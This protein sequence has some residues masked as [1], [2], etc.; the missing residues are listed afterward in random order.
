MGDRSE[1]LFKHLVSAAVFAAVLITSVFCS[2]RAYGAEDD[3]TVS[4]QLIG[5][6]VYQWDFPY[7]DDLFRSPSEYFSTEL[8][9]ASTGLMVSAFNCEPEVLADQYQ[10]YLKGAG[11]RDIYEFG[12]DQETSKDSLAGIIGWKQID[13]FILIA[14]APR[15][16]GYGKEWAGNLE[17]GDEERHVGFN[18]AAQI[19][20]GEITRYIDGHHLD[21]AMKLWLTGF[22]RAS[23][24]S[25]LAAADMIDSGA[26][27][28]VYAYLF[29]VPRTTKDP[30]RLEYTGIFNICGKN[31]PV[32]NVPLES[33]GYERYGWDRFT[34]SVETDIHYLELLN[35]ASMVNSELTGYP[36]YYNPEINYQIHLIL[37]FLAKMFPT[38]KEYAEEFQDVIMTV[39]TE[40]E[41]E[42]MIPILQEALSQLN[43]LD[44]EEERSCE[45][46]LEY[47][48]F[49]ASEHLAADQKQVKNGYWDPDQSI[50][51]NV[52]R[53]HCPYVYIS[54]VFSGCEESRLFQTPPLFRRVSLIGNVDVAV[55]QDGRF[56]VGIDSQGNITNKEDPDDLSTAFIMR[57][58]DMTTVSLPFLEDF[59]LE[60]R[61]NKAGNLIYYNNLCD[62]YSTYGF[63][64][65]VLT[66]TLEAGE[67]DLNIT[68]ADFDGELS[69]VNGRIFNRSQ[70]D[71]N[72]SPTLVM[73]NEIGN[74]KY[75]TLEGLFQMIFYSLMAILAILFVCMV[76][77]II[78]A[79]RKKK[80]NAPYAPWF[81]IIPHLMIAI[82]LVLLTQ[83]FTVNMYSIGHMRAVC[84]GLT[85]LVMFLLS[86]RG[87]I[88]NRTLPGL[89]IAVG[90]LILGFVNAVIYQRST[91]VSASVLHFV[92]YC[93]CMAGLACI[94]VS[95]FF[96]KK[97][98]PKAA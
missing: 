59:D 97:R 25:N 69:A 52:I 26:F 19:F 8:A 83:F 67:Y 37:E 16:N 12:Y 50:A 45:V 77:A 60:I 95:T 55:R 1:R 3:I 87:L 46:L 74:S 17:V 70:I 35:E 91:L 4:F 96:I 20:E 94:A 49:I 34:P 23:A 92:I 98:Q 66:Q 42:R 82:V 71:F 2:V 36:L 30:N 68:F 47:F 9:R 14:A 75:M 57:N 29:G 93:L 90:F 38:N 88:R 64:N 54:W 89:L 80:R 43:D 24:V 22:S 33:W 53:E 61:A 76:I 5:K 31:D 41:P 18:R 7:S 13:D 21:G 51:E 73:A 28:D 10:V 39:W 65:K 79:I 62:S 78:H 27:E 15:G 84:A 86:L 32:T 63:V 44:A 6:K 58:G 85:M 72:Y 48:S 56:L 40:A 81:V 11:F